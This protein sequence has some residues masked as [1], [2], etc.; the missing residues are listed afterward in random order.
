MRKPV[1]GAHDRLLSWTME[2]GQRA[3]GEELQALRL[4]AS[5]ALSG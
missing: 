2:R 3:S 4:Q 5:G 1:E